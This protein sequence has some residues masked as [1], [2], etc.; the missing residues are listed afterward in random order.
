MADARLVTVAGYGLLTQGS[1]TP[2]MGAELSLHESV[3]QSDREASPP[4]SSSRRSGVI[5]HEFSVLYR[6]VVAVS[7]DAGLSGAYPCA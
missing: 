3:V 6:A 1:C 2:S 4:S 7:V 5:H